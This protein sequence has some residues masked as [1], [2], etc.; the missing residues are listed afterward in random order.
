L[1]AHVR[2]KGRVKLGDLKVSFDRIA[3]AANFREM[4]DVAAAVTANFL[5]TL[6]GMIQALESALREQNSA[7]LMHAAH[8]LKG[9][10]AIFCAEPARQLAWRLESLGRSQQLAEAPTVLVELQA[11]LK[12]LTAEL[13]ASEFR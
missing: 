9:A 11:E 4:P 6:P 8:S 13:R 10:V 1:P 5:S 7:N 3:F 12:A 2:E